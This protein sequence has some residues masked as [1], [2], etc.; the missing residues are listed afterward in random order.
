M[1]KLINI[2]TK[3]SILV[4]GIMVLSS[5]SQE[6]K[7]PDY[8]TKIDSLTTVLA[9]DA[10]AFQTIDTTLISS[11]IKNIESQLANLDLID[12]S[13]RIPERIN[14]SEIS[15]SFKLFLEENNQIIEE[16]NFSKKQLSNLR[17]D[18]ENEL[19]NSDDLKLYFEQE[20]EAVAILQHKMELYQKKINS[21][22]DNYEVFNSKI[23]YLLDSLSKN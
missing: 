13:L 12:S 18:T 6:K 15:K 1:R 22:L 7:R 3:L 11:K 2:Q 19:L 4:A 8:L 5:C 16:I 20:C 17:I 9:N 21:Q 10:S 23:G 14:Y